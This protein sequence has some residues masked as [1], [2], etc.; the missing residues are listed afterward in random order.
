MNT[1]RKQ[2]ATE[3]LNALKKAAPEMRAQTCDS[4]LEVATGGEVRKHWKKWMGSFPK[5]AAK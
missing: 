3:R 4:W 1:N 5:W 2:T